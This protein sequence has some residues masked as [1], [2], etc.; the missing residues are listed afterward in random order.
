MNWN[1]VWNCLNKESI[2]WQTFAT[3]KTPYSILLIF[4]LFSCTEKKSPA[5]QIRGLNTSDIF[6]F[7]SPNHLFIPDH[8][9]NRTRQFEKHL[10][11]QSLENG[12]D[13][14]QIRLHYGGP[15]S[16]DRLVILTNKDDKWTAE[17]SKIITEVNPKFGNP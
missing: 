10:G 9:I 3:M 6:L 2:G 15:M 14:I 11:L 12:F 16:G 4:L 5:E 8:Y 1:K 17:I 7:E 13:S